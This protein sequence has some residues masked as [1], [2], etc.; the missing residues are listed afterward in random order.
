MKCYKCG[1]KVTIKDKIAFLATYP[2][3]VNA[4][5]KRKKI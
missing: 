4:C 5:P 3:H 2:Y 1:R